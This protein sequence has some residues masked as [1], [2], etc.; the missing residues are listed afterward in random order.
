MPRKSA[1]LNFDERLFNA[2][3]EGDEAAREQVWAEL[4]AVLHRVA[5][6]YCR[7][8]C[9]NESAA[10]EMAEDAVSKTWQLMEGWTIEWQGQDSFVSLATKCLIKQCQGELRTFWRRANRETP[11]ERDSTEDEGDTT[12]LLD[13]LG[14]AEAPAEDRMV[15][16]QLKIEGARETLRLLAAA[17]EAC[18]QKDG[19]ESALAKTIGMTEAYVRRRLVKASVNVKRA[20]KLTVDDL[21]LEADLDDFSLGKERMNRFLMKSLK[22]NR[23]TLDQRMLH[24]RALLKKLR[25]GGQK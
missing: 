18:R 23:N 14:F 24:L 7:G 1:K 11:V 9:R 5:Y 22:I 10:E 20:R 12:N 2:W 19:T 13:Y 17:R 6:K 4:W 8:L 15:T 25:E 21:L 16:A 3:K